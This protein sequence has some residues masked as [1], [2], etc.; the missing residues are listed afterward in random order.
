MT[1]KKLFQIPSRM[2]ICAVAVMLATSAL[3]FGQADLSGTWDN[4]SGIDFLNPV[5]V[6]D[7]VCVVACAEVTPIPAPVSNTPRAAPARPVYKSQFLAR[8]QELNDT[9]VTTDPVLR[10]NPPGVPRIGPPDKIVQ[11]PTE[12][13]FLYDDVAGNF[14]R[15]IPVDGRAHRTDVEASFLGDAVGVWEGATLVVE[16]THFNTDSWLTDDGSFHTANLRVEERISRDG[17]ELTWQATAF[18]DEILAEPWKIPVRYAT[19]TDV[20]IVEAPLCLEQ[21]LEHIVDGTHHDNPR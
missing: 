10:C 16:T 20:E 12:I 6:G 13:I 3:V 14:F 21:D 7:S 5:V 9:Q 2:R 19:S 8:V 4:G 18:D 17:D 11:T 1:T 15:V